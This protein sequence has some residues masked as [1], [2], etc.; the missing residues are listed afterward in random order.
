MTLALALK[1][2]AEDIEAD[3]FSET[4]VQFY[5][6]EYGLNPALVERKFQEQ[7][8]CT[9]E[10]FAPKAAARAANKEM[11]RLGEIAAAERAKEQA[12]AEAAAISDFYR[13]RAAYDEA[14]AIAAGYKSYSDMMWSLIGAL[15]KS[16]RA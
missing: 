12:A 8:G 2:I 13:Q 15:G 3:G 16:L 9:P 10:A 7:F 1:N 4:I 5:C 11:F 14:R 6:E